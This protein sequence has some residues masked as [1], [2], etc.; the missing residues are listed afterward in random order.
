MLSVLDRCYILLHGRR[1]STSISAASNTTDMSQMSDMSSVLGKHMKR[2]VFDCVKHRL[3]K[4]DHN[5]YDIIWPSVKRLPQ[6][7]AFRIALEQDFPIGIVAPD[8]H[9][10]KVFEE[11][12]DPIIK[13]VNNIGTCGWL[14]GYPSTPVSLSLSL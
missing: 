2:Y 13:E 9:V 5:F 4:L 8:F 6:E 12:L 1:N 14:E 11:Y 3:T 10:Y 7:R